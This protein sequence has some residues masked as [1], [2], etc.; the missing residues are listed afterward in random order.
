[1]TKVFLSAGHG[2]SDPGAT[3]NGLKEKEIN[4]QIMLACRDYLQD[5]GYKVIC[6]RVKDENDPV[7]EEV[8]EAN[9]SGAD[10]AVSFHTNAGGGDGSESFYYS[11][12]SKGKK[13]AELCEKHIKAIG[14]N[15]R[16]VKTNNLMFTRSTKMVA[17]LCECA[18][19]DTKKD[20]EIVDTKAEQKEFG[21]AYAKAIIEYFGG[22]VSA[23]NTSTST[24]TTSKPTTSANN[25]IAEV[26]EWTNKTYGYSQKVDG[27]NGTN[28]KKGLVIA[29]QTE[30]NK[31]FGKGLT[32]DGIAGK[33]T[34]AAAVNVRKG[35]KGN[36]TRVLQGRLICLGYYDGDFDGDF[37]SKTE[38]AVKEFQKANGLTKDG[39][40]GPKTWAA[41]F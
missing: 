26:Q 17:V 37:G 19:I 23:S 33:K 27:I 25:K 30:L 6:S 15:S 7:Q 24:T 9:A 20:I 13:L 41:L 34:E 39:V 16:G 22:K 18:F 4:L 29:Y 10:V 3:G 28:T 1:M 40:A 8:R 2:G 32:V 36:L 38:E 11:G 35:A 31:Q 12:S 5:K 21:E 14:Q